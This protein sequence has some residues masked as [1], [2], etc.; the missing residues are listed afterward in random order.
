M[1]MSAPVVSEGLIW[2][3]GYPLTNT[4]EVQVVCG[5]SGEMLTPIRANDGAAGFRPEPG[6]LVFQMERPG[7]GAEPRVR[8]Y[9]YEGGDL[10]VLV[11]EGSFM[12]IE[13]T[14]NLLDALNA[15]GGEDGKAWC[16]H[17]KCLHYAN[18]PRRSR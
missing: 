4:A 18:P 5:T 13:V 3:S 17:C 8:L 2:E 1:Y 14:D 6:M 16:F 12:E 15:I 10:F 7:G 11:S 9:R